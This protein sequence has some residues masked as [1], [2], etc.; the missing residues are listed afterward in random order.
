MSI[1]KL[2]RIDIL[3]DKAVALACRFIGAAHRDGGRLAVMTSFGKD[4]MV[5]LDVMR[6]AAAHMRTPMPDCI[7][8][9]EPFEAGKYAWG[10]RM[11]EVFKL[12]VYDWRPSGTA[13]QQ[14][15]DEFEVQNYYRFGPHGIMTCPTGILPWNGEGDFRCALD[16]FLNKPLA[17][18]V[19]GPWT[20]FMVGHKG[21]DADPIYGGDAGT[22]VDW[23]I[24]PAVGEF[25]FPLR[26]W[27]DADV[28]AYTAEFDVPQNPD[29]YRDGAQQLDDLRANPDYFTACT[30][31]LDRRPGAPRFVECPK[32]GAV[33]ENVSGRV[34]WAD[35]SKPS[36]ME[37][38]KQDA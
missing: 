16:D 8:F 3:A 5:L 19:N 4:S 38:D 1:D 24:V 11:A 13:M 2:E 37:G 10:Q 20:H 14:E 36:Y 29:R 15:G 32:R 28:W 12:T 34:P 30:A 26:E 9:R 6:R 18:P 23:R 33:I 35:Q 22:R 21:S 27:T 31:C 17:P 7:C 25:C